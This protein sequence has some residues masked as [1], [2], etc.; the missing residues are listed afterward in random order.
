[1][2]ARVGATRWESGPDG[3]ESV[4]QLEQCTWRKSMGQ[5]EQRTWRKSVGQLEQCTWRRQS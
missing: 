5:L 3:V 4:G 1:M 2:D